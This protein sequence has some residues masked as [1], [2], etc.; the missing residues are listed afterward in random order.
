MEAE[1]SL[2]RL[3]SFAV[4]APVVILE[5]GGERWGI[6]EEGVVLGDIPSGALFYVA[7][8]PAL[9]RLDQECQQGGG[10]ARGGFDNVYAV[11]RAEV[12]LPAEE[13]FQ[14][15]LRER[16]GLLLQLNKKE[17]FTW[18]GQLPADHVPAQLKLAGMQIEEF[19]RGFMCYGILLGSDEFVRHQLQQKS[20][21]II[22]DSV[23]MVDVLSG[24]R[25]ALWSMLR[26]S[27][28]SRFEYVCQLAPP[29]LSEPAA[30]MLDSHLWTV[31]E[32]SLI[33]GVRTVPL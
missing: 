27:T 17:W 19:Y 31:L 4:L 15:D 16:C 3:T 22:D 29:S 23:K 6:A 28:M 2:V 12:V 13:R 8:Q 24:D 25:Q 9:I 5:S 26:L 14:Q 33:L 21:E 32:A 11:G 7:Q 1:E 10:F 18:N 30:S 20:Q